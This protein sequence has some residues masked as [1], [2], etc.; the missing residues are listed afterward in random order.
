LNIR[1]F[2][3]VIIIIQT[4]AQQHL[5]EF[6]NEIERKIHEIKIFYENDKQEIKRQH[7]RMHQDLLDETNQVKIHFINII[8]TRIFFDF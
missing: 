7:S 8:F 2:L 3:F 4:T 5:K 6:E 1:F